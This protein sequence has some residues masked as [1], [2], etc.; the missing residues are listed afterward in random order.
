M[1]SR[2]QLKYRIHLADRCKKALCAKSIKVID[3][4]RIGIY[5][6]SI[7]VNHKSDRHRY[8][9]VALLLSTTALI[10]GSV[11][12]ATAEESKNQANNQI[13][14]IV[15]PN[16]DKP[17]P[18]GIFFGGKEVGNLDIIPKKDQLLLPLEGFAKLSDIKIDKIGDIT[19]LKTPIG[20]VEI[21]PRDI[22]DIQGIQY[23]SDQT[24]EQ[25]LYTKIELNQSEFAIVVDLPWRTGRKVAIVPE[26]LTP[27]FT[28]P[29]NSVSTLRQ[30]FDSNTRIG[31]STDLRSSTLLTGRLFDNAWRLRLDTNFNSTTELSEYFLYNRKG[32][33]GYQIGKQDISLHPLLN[34]INLTGVQ[35]GF[36]NLPPERFFEAN[37]ATELLPRRAFPI[38][39]FRGF[40]PPTSFVLLRVGGAVIA[41][42]QVGLSG[43]YEFPDINLSS[44][45]LNQ[46][47]L[48]IFDRR[49]LNTPSEI[50]KFSFNTSDLLLPANGSVQ[51]VGGGAIGNLLNRAFQSNNNTD[52]NQ[53]KFAGFYQVRQ[54]ISD[55]LT[56]EGAIQ[57]LPQNNGGQHITQGQVGAVARIF[58]PL[59]V[60]ASVGQSSLGKTAYSTDFNLNL[61][62]LRVQGN[63]DY[64][65]ANYNTG[66]ETR[67]RFNRSVDV[68]Y[69]VSSS[70]DV[71]ANYRDRQDSS[72]SI[73]YILPSFNWRPTNNVSVFGRSGSNAEYLYNIYYQPSNSARISFAGSPQNNALDLSYTFDPTLQGSFG[74]SFGDNN[75]PL[76]SFLLTSGGQQPGDLSWGIGAAF[77]NG[78]IR[79][80]ANASLEIIPG[81]LGRIDYRG[82]P[83]RNFGV[84]NGT[85]GDQFSIS[86]VTDLAFNQGGVVPANSNSFSRGRGNIAGKIKILNGDKLPSFNLSGASVSIKQ[87]ERGFGNS[88]VDD[89]GNFFIGNIPD[90]TYIVEIEPNELPVELSILKSS[91][92]AR[93]AGGATTNVEF[94]LQAEFGVAGRIRDAQGKTQPNISL[95]LTNIQGVVVKST[96]T[97]EFGLYRIDG[98]PIGKYKIQVVSQTT[99]TSGKKQPV[100]DLEIRDRFL[101]D[102][103][104]Q[105]LSEP[106]L[107]PTLNPTPPTPT[108]SSSQLT[109]PSK[110]APIPPTQ[111]TNISPSVSIDRKVN[112]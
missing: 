70:L 23:I 21:S 101:F 26:T 86:L 14:E 30:Q 36:T 68:T 100:L 82:F 63:A 110:Q 39:T 33:F 91:R 8:F 24:L 7:A 53:G 37:Q 35:L 50:R 13:P 48:L 65:P 54:G 112:F 16:T 18:I 60:S 31:G 93:V 79:P 66:N 58:D 38:Q 97:D 22:Q 105:I 44:S 73:S 64:F 17:I 59:V 56:L 6:I 83:A 40:V 2:L 12:V 15:F 102:R 42:Q 41:Q 108:P 43:Y 34:S 104:L 61:N 45:S 72:S 20:I 29:S 74:Y 107:S 9:L 10:F 96:R 92:V 47:E 94:D 75:N 99:S 27:E 49:N 52:A 51:L 88:Q 5:I 57:Y 19:K 78:E 109:S 4:Q 89:R 77:S 28:P 55:G 95:Q 1:N 87:G 111:P 32:N 25:K 76:Y 11:S 98:I 46:V 85:S 69:R 62:D 80:Q 81:L 106:D 103:D 90:G 67:D 3:V 71:G 84:N